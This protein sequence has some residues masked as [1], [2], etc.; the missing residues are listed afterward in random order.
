MNCALLEI[1]FCVR[2]VKSNRCR[3]CL[4]VSRTRAFWCVV[5]GLLEILFVYNFEYFI[6]FK[7]FR[8]LLYIYPTFI[9]IRTST[10]RR[11]NSIIILIKF[12]LNYMLK[13]EIHI[14]K[15]INYC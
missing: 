6:S 5:A 13:I 8:I 9:R 1:L 15:I 4:E 12:L 10:V 2:F 14:Q 7:S 3:L 11:K